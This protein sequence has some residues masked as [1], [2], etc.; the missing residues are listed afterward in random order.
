[1]TDRELL[2]YFSAETRT[3]GPRTVVMVAHPDDETIGA[4]GR[5]AEIDPAAIV[6]ATDGA[7][8]DPW[9]AREAGCAG[10]AEYAALRRRELDAALEAGGVPPERVRG[11]SFTDQE[12]ALQ[13]EALTRATRALF[14]E[15]RP[16]VV[17][18]HP[19]EGGHPDHDALAFAV[20]SA[21]RALAP[22]ARP[23]VLELAFYHQGTHGPVWGRFAGEPG[24]TITLSGP[25]LARKR[26]MMRC[27]RSQARVL[28]P[29]PLELERVRVA[30]DYDFCAPPDAAGFY[31]DAFRWARSGAEFLACAAEARAHLPS[32]PLSE[33]D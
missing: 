19:Y 24:R 28:A 32:G 4:G 27:Y 9:F 31:Y 6:I 22:A 21:R 2:D 8:G 7:P 12:A 10:R 20:H 25:R 26:A 11:W 3:R 33:T 30:P 16:E 29:F 23:A 17:L 14:E 18:T 1:V 15:L 5:L 13:L